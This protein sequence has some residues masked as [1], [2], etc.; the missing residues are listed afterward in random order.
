MGEISAMN[1]PAHTIAEKIS[2]MDETDCIAFRIN[3]DGTLDYAPL[4]MAMRNIWLFNDTGGARD[5]CG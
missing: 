4:P 5:V 2:D 3:L 1:K